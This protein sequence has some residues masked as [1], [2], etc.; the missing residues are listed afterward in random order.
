MRPYTSLVRVLDGA[1]DLMPKPWADALRRHHEMAKFAIVGGSTF[2][3]DTGIFYWLK[4]PPRWSAP[5]SPRW[6]RTS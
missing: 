2:I 5:L 1:L 3:L 6:C 4:S